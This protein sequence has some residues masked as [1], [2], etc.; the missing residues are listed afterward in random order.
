M[1]C[2]PKRILHLFYLEGRQTSLPGKGTGCLLFQ[3][4]M[5]RG[6]V[7]LDY[8]AKLE[9]REVSYIWRSGK[10]YSRKWEKVEALGVFEEQQ[11]GQSGWG[12]LNKGPSGKFA[13]IRYRRY[14]KNH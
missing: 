12:T 13:D 11:G 3:L 6:T 5:D 7:M 14:P 8:Y 4:P 2:L 9:G 10:E 1:F